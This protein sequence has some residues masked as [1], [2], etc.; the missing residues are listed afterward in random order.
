MTWQINY[1]SDTEKQLKRLDTPVRIRV[2]RFLEERVATLEN[3]RC[4]GETLSGPLGDYWKYRVG[5]CR[6]ICNIQDATITILVIKIGNR[7]EVY[8]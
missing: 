4:I 8:R 2:T 7:R 1:Q 5:D 6:I 3:P